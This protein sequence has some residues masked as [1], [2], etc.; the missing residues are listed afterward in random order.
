M[1]TTTILAIAA[2][3]GVLACLLLPYRHLR[4]SAP[5]QHL[6]HAKLESYQRIVHS[7]QALIAGLEEQ[8]GRVSRYLSDSSL[9]HIDELQQVAEQTDE[10]AAGFSNAI[11]LHA[12]LMPAT[13]VAQLNCMRAQLSDNNP[14]DSKPQSPELALKEIDGFISHMVLQANQVCTAMRHDL[15]LEPLQ[16]PLYLRGKPAV[17]EKLAWQ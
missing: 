4:Y 9:S 14:L 16:H 13:V 8:F 7:L 1:M 3:L 15:H 5:Q 17:T 2:A 6:Y 12:L 11:T 10:L